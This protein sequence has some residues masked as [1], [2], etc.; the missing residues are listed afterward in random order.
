MTKSRV[1]V[2]GYY[3]KAQVKKKEIIVT[4]FIIL[5]TC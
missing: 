5:Y 3:Q 4:I 1:I 2:R